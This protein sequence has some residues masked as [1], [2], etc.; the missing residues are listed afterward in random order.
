M[1]PEET[2]RFPYFA[3]RVR[4]L[5]DDYELASPYDLIEGIVA[6]LDPPERIGAKEA[7]EIVEHL[8]LAY[9]DPRLVGLRYPFRDGGLE[10]RTEELKM[11]LRL[12]PRLYARLTYQSHPGED[13]AGILSAVATPLLMQVWEEECEDLV[14]NA[15]RLLNMLFQQG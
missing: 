5:T 4:E 9:T 14:E 10:E 1:K 6:Q 12:F 2:V 7:R 15:E 11:C 3:Y 13:T 8:K